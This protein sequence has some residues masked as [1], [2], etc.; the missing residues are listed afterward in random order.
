MTRDEEIEDIRANLAAMLQDTLTAAAYSQTI[1]RLEA[2]LK[3]L[4]IEQVSTSAAPDEIAAYVVN[5]FTGDHYWIDKKAAAV[6]VA[7]ALVAY[8]AA[9]AAAERERCLDAIAGLYH[10]DTCRAAIRSLDT[11]AEPY[12]CPGCGRPTSVIYNRAN[13]PACAG[14]D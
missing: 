2:R 6:D 4:E 11:P 12:T 10:G 14:R 13:C 8:G 5:N 9:R 7:A 3:V 1:E